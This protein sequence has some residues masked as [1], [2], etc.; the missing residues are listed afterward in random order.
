[1][2]QKMKNI[3]INS[4]KTTK[5]KVFLLLFHCTLIVFLSCAEAIEPRKP[6]EPTVPPRPPGPPGPPG[7]QIPMEVINE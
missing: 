5:N 1:M 4:H 6:E 7:P 3:V 2:V